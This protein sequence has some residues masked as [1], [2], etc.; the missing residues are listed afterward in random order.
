M[1]T[2]SIL[3]AF[4]SFTMLINAFDW[5]RLFEQTNFYVELIFETLK[6]IRCAMYLFVMSL[7]LFG[8]PLLLLNYNITVDQ[9]GE[10]V[11]DEVVESTFGFWPSNVL[12]N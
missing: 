7:F 4:S 2:L 11:S 12:I 10:K 1:D 6:D 8:I 3:A 9:S 5:L